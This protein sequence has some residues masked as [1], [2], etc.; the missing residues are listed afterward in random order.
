MATGLITAAIVIVTIAACAFFLVRFGE[1][2]EAR[3]RNLAKAQAAASISGE[4][5]TDPEKIAAEYDRI[6]SERLD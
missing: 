5:E 4:I 6:R 1:G 2:R 3:K